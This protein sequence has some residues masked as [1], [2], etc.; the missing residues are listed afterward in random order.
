MVTRDVYLQP[1]APDPVLDDAIVLALVR[2]HAP[3]AAGV[4]EVDESG[5]EARAYVVDG[6][7]ILKTQRPHR[8]RPRTSLA[9]EVC[10][11]QQLRREPNLPV[12]EV[13]GYGREGPIEYLCMTRIPGVAMRRL[14]PAPEQRIAILRELGR[15]L[16]RIHATDQ[17]RLIESDLFPGD[18]APADFARR[19][20]EAFELAVE[21]IDAL[22]PGAW[23]LD[24]PPESVA[25]RALAA[26]PWSDRFVALHSN[27]GPEHVFWDPERGGLTGL[28]DFGDAYIS[29]PALDLRPWRD[30]GDRAA[31]MAGYLDLGEPDTAFGAV[32]RVSLL[33]GELMAIARRRQRPE[34]AA[35]NLR[36][37]LAE[38]TT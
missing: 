5:G 12:P 9:K 23:P 27:P 32:L 15:V 3:R 1:E 2:R 34:R 35:V 25:A 24:E 38:L 30:A 22:P 29:H 13:L 28:I 8:L 6:D 21:G 33:L 17:Q 11:L 37:L 31:L 16:R 10:F 4:T 18:R 7:I 19:M 36:A 26:L 20:R 14:A